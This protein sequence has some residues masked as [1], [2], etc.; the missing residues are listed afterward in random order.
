MSEKINL[1]MKFPLWMARPV[2][3]TLEI[4]AN[5]AASH[6]D[7]LEQSDYGTPS[8]PAAALAKSTS[9]NGRISTVVGNRQASQ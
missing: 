5:W 6:D 7:D 3:N 9:L 8:C 1:H 4:Y 2:K